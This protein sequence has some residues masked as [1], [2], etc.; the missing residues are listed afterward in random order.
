[1]KPS[2]RFKLRKIVT[3]QFAGFDEMFDTQSNV[4]V[5]AGLSFGIEENERIIAVA[6]TIRYKCDE[7]PSPF[8]MIEVRMFFDIEEATWVGLHDDQKQV[9]TIDKGFAQH[10]G[11]LVIG[12]TRGILFAK[13]E[14]SD[15]NK[16]VLPL[17][18]VENIVNE[19]ILIEIDETL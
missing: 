19:D 8:L 11:V 12:T 4:E 15:F 16:W 7:K 9:I 13:T 6:C 1:M 2:I 5:S 17:I 10:L 14:G 3:E 18:N